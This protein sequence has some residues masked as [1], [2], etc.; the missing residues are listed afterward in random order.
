MSATARL[1]CDLRFGCLLAAAPGSALTGGR[2]IFHTQKFDTAT[3][4]YNIPSHYY[5]FDSVF[6]NSCRDPCFDQASNFYCS[7]V[8]A[9]NI[10]MYIKFKL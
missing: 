7:T 6:F 4:T 5:Y 9:P 10:F 8:F 1:V 3:H 2:Q